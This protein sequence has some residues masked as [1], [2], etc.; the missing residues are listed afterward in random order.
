MANLFHQEVGAASTQ[1]CNLQSK[2]GSQEP[3][4]SGKKKYS[5]CPNL[6]DLIL[7]VHLVENI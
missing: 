3:S 7:K 2:I 1:H 6:N 5:I 4:F